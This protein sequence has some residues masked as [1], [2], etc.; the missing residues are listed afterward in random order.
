M[1][2]F[3]CFLGPEVARKMPVRIIVPQGRSRD[4]VAM[5]DNVWIEYNPSP[6]GARVGD[7][8]VR[9][10]AKALNVDWYEAYALLAAKGY[11]LLD[12]PSSNAVW[13]AVLKD[14]GFERHLIPNTCPSCYT[15]GDFARDHPFGTYVV[16]T[17]NH[18]VTI[19]SG[20]VW[21]SWDSSNEIAFYF[22][23]KG[24]SSSRFQ[25]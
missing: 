23:E 20:S 24:D 17:G 13:G 12:M 3:F 21:D 1:G 15:I 14:N 5:K 7:C 18:V 2:V 10:I 8:S 11:D 19:E 4:N 6:A 25:R 9:A 22:W 16:G